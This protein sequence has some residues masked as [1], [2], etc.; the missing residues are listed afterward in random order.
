[1]MQSSADKPY[2]EVPSRKKIESRRKK[3]ITCCVLFVIGLTGTGYTSIETPLNN[4]CIVMFAVGLYG[5][6]GFAIA[7]H[8][9]KKHYNEA[10]T[11]YKNKCSEINKENRIINIMNLNQ[12]L[13]ICQK[14]IV[15]LQRKLDADE[16]VQERIGGF[17]ELFS[18][19]GSI[20]SEE[21]INNVNS[22]ISQKKIELETLINREKVLLRQLENLGAP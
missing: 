20:N 1:M 13:A 6:I 16:K 2:P 11:I 8:S 12:E 22:S 3:L 7:L 4:V 15:A 19:L 5:G 14:R 17:S 9:A 21:I 18:E 10:V